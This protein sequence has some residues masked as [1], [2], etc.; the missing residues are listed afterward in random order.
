MTLVY[1]DIYSFIDRCNRRN[2]SKRVFKIRNNDP[3]TVLL[4][5]VLGL[6]RSQ[7]LLLRP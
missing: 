2:V 1:R 6:V 5:L 4:A 3:K 7:L